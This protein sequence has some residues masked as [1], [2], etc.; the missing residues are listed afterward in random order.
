MDALKSQSEKRENIMKTIFTPSGLSLRVE[1]PQ[2]QA[3]K[4]KP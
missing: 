4:G 3:F 1:D 2:G